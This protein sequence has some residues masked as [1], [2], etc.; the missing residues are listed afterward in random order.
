MFLM[1]LTS[2]SQWFLSLPY[3]PVYKIFILIIFLFTYLR[4]IVDI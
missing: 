1:V 2:V 4:E 3:D